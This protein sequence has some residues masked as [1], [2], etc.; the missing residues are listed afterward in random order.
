M[1][2]I[3][4]C[5]IL[6]SF[7]ANAVVE[8]YE[9]EDETLRIRYQQFV[10]EL[11]CPMCQNQ[12][13]AG[14]NSSI[15]EDLRKE[16]YRLLH[17][18]RSDQQIVEYMVNRYGD[19]IL[20]RPRFNLETAALWLAPVLFLVLGL[21]VVVVI[22]LRQRKTVLTDDVTQTLDESEQQQLQQLLADT[23]RENK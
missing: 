5:L 17:E 10:E 4:C 6:V 7:A 19:F 15:S 12:N 3:L 21:I 22:F 13:L 23:E 20:Y 1:K 2:I 18:G 8:T 11:R 9:F 14:S 16:I